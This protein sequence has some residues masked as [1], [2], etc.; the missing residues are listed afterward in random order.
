MVSPTLKNFENDFF[1][2]RQHKNTKCDKFFFYSALFNYAVKKRNPTIFMPFTS[3]EL[4]F[5]VLLNEK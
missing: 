5:L 2:E 1:N 4:R 3:K